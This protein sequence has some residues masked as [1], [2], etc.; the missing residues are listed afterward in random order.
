MKSVPI[1][2]G[3]GNVIGRACYREPVSRCATAGCRGVGTVLCDYPITRRGR[4]TTCSRRVC[5]ACAKSVGN[6]DFCPPHARA[7]E[8]DGGQLVT[9]CAACFSASC[10]ER[11]QGYTCPARELVGTKTLTIAQWKSALSFGVLK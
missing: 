9:V 6:Q 2:D 11:E 3:A 10:G 4:Q 5:Q 8:Q 1:R 7:I